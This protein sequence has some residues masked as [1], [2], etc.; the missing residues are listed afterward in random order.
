MKKWLLAV[1]LIVAGGL[2]TL[3]AADFWQTKKYTDWSE[4]E[5]LK[6]L[7]DSPW[8][9]KASIPRP[10]MGAPGGKGGGGGGKGGG[11]AFLPQDEGG[12]SSGGSGGGG[13]GGGG[14]KGGGGGMGGGGMSFSNEVELT[15]RWITALPIKQANVIRQYGK[16]AGTSPDAAKRLARE[17]QYYIAQI[18]GYPGRLT[19]EA[20]TAAAQLVVKGV[21]PVAPVQVEVSPGAASG[22]GAPP[23]NIFMVFPKA[24]T[25]G[26]ILKI[27]DDEVEV[28]V[29]MP[30]LK[31][32]RKFKLKDMVFNG[33]LEI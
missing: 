1:S 26:H 20:V 22:R 15:V 7:S 5:V 11:M 6:I 10:P 16:E 2:Y 8:A 30:G 23:S 27:E 14:G 18:E 13:G 19:P 4:K 24:Q 3:L 29:N 33:K 31:M 32:K 28:V 25:G 21:P 9:A 17:E 12:G